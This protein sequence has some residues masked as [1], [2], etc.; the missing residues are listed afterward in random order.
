M[1]DKLYPI[2]YI[3]SSLIIKE[4]NEKSNTNRSVQSNGRD[5]AGAN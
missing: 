3:K 2:T 1:V 4:K 5:E